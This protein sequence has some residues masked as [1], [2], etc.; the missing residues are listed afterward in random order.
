[1]C[2]RVRA[3]VRID[4]VVQGVGFRPFVYRT[5]LDAGVGGYVRNA[6]GY[7]DATFEGD[8]QAVDAVLKTLRS[9]NPPLS[10]V[11]A[12]DV[13]WSD[14][15]GVDVFEIRNSQS[16]EA[17]DG[18]APMP[19]DTGI[20]DQCLSDVRNAESRYHGY[21]ATSCVDCGP[22]YTVV[23]DVPYDRN[24]TS[25]DEFP[26][27]EDCRDSYTDPSDRRYHAQAIACPVCGPALRYEEN[28]EPTE[29]GH[30]ALDRAGHALADGAILGVKGIGGT[31]L[32]CDATDEATVAKLR[33]RTGRQ[34]KPF[35]VMAPSLSS[36]ESFADVGAAD[37]EHL[38]DIRRPITVLEA[39]D[40]EWLCSVA[41]GLHTVGVMLPYSGLHHLLFDRIDVP[42]V[43][44]SANRPGEPMVTTG[45]ALW[46]KLGDVVDGALLH[47]RDIVARCDDS[48]VRTVGGDARFL[49]RSRGWTPRAL[50]NPVG[51][52]ATPSVLAVGPGRDV[53]VAV[54]DDQRVVLSQHVGDVDGPESLSFHRKSIER[55]VQLTGIDAD[56]V[57][58]DRHPDFTTTDE[59]RRI[60]QEGLDGPVRVG[61]HHAHAA[62]L[63]A[64]HD[65]ERAVVVT[66]DGTGYGPDGT[67]WGGEVLDTR[68][69]EVTRIG[70][71]APFS[72]PGGDEAVTKPARILA[73]V[74]DDPTIV[75]TQLVE[76]GAVNTPKEAAI[77]REQA[78][79]GVNAPTTTSAGRFLDAI[80]SLLGVCDRRRYQGEPALRLEAAAS[81]GTARDIALPFTTHESRRVL[82]TKELT[83]RLARMLEESSANDVAATAQDALAR[84]LAELAVETARDRS[85]STVG[86]TGG[87]AYNDAI[88]TAFRD[89]VTDAGLTFL[90]PD[91]VPPGDGG[92]S[93]GQAIVATARSHSTPP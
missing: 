33:E 52:V 18:R 64:E 69:S 36:V 10:V 89:T 71:L 21:W 92:I 63:C 87:V 61:H 84:G 51:G 44:T 7:V 37:R 30:D 49:R 39:T 26:M 24:R 23:R 45:P 2:A 74:L 80:S 70:G 59:A 81:K 76:T 6:G 65:I 50:P 88:F 42:L 12:I 43:M 15:E 35:A 91:R 20:C 56:T 73:S 85:L 79:K 77:V 40:D 67:I 46:D 31:H 83:S 54:A 57:A 34:T 28:A 9:E 60:A 82:D 55:L 58:C 14:P 29:S 47:D 90:G 75:D 38:A 13:T 32:V 53:T 17:D 72:L 86:F 68:Y 11:A 5:A 4:G 66:A 27:C 48:V 41:P 93:Y 1:M 62:A 3:S 8:R 25:M 22:R 16:G 78:E 19:P